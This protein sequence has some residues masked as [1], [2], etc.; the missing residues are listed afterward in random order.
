MFAETIK[1]RCYKGQDTDEII[2]IWNTQMPLNQITKDM[3]VKS[4]LLDLNFDPQGFFV[5]CHGEEILGFVY[6]VNQ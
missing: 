4:I 5:A 6:A 3:F 1:V 2:Q